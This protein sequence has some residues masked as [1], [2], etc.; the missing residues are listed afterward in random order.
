MAS[1]PD[2]EFSG[3]R[4]T[5]GPSGRIERG[6]HHRLSRTIM[7][8]SGLL[9]AGRI[10][11]TIITIVGMF[12]L[13]RLLTPADFGVL[14]IASSV[15]VLSLVILEGVIDYPT[16]RDDDLTIE[17]LRNL[18]W[19]GI[20]LTSLF[21]AA[22]WFAAPLAE[23]QLDF[24]H[25]ALALRAMIPVCIA[26]VFF[27][28]GTGVLRRQHRFGRAS[29]LSIFTVALYMAGAVALTLSGLGIEG[30]LIGL[31]GA[32]VVT[33]LLLIAIARLPLLPPRRISGTAEHYR[34]G[35]YGAL[36]RLINWA[37]TTVDTVA[38]AM[39]L[40]P[41]ATGIYSR[42]Y[43]INVQAKEP[44]LAID[45]TMRQAFASARAQ[46]SD[47]GG[48]MLLA[49]RL[50]TLASGLVAAALVI[51][52]E[53]IVAILLGAQWG[54]A[55][56]PLAIL[57]LGLPPRIAR[58]YFDGLAVVVGDVRG[59]MLRHL[60]M[61]AMIVAGLALFARH[62]LPA[63]AAA[64]T[65]PLYL[66][67]AFAVGHRERAMLGSVA[68][69][70]RAMLPGLALG[71]ALIAADHLLLRPLADDNLWLHAALASAWLIGMTS[72]IALFAPPALIGAQLAKLRRKVL[73]RLTPAK[74]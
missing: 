43:N 20:G 4:G 30:V 58:L 24:P 25:L 42:A 45:Q 5:A 38:V 51:L 11:R 13:A 49:L 3:D 71:T 67:L 22:L 59:A 50:I 62:G 53:Q 32:N 60:A 73:D 35:G 40:G 21:G 6:T 52:R 46:S 37:W 64:V 27:V 65:V 69:L 44:F 31:V 39:L 41:A 19:A 2:D 63:V 66:S 16:I 26:Q 7:R 68:Q 1:E 9:I 36:S 8:G 56:A 15:T 57:A 14:A 47:V 33:A 48:Q 72:A 34:L 28:A 29:L 74:G 12:I 10:V 61:L 23:R 55:A 18:V 70:C 17:R 54:A